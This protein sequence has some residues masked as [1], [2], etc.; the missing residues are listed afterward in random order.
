MWKVIVIEMGPGCEGLGLPHLQSPSQPDEAQ[1]I[2]AL[3]N[4]SLGEL[5]LCNSKLQ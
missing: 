4:S 3:C 2:C 5:C 1:E